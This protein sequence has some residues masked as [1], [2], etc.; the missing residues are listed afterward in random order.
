M[1][2]VCAVQHCET[3]PH[4]PA[5]WRGGC[6]TT[7]RRLLFVVTVAQAPVP[8]EILPAG[9][10]EPLYRLP[11]D[12][13][14]GELPVLPL[15]ITGA[16]RWVGASVPRAGCQRCMTVCVGA[17]LPRVGCQQCMTVWM[18]ASLPRAGC[19]RCMIVWMHAPL[20]R[21]GC[22]RCMTVCPTDD[23]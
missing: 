16:I 10:Y 19:Q 5:R 6:P 11:L 18:Q 8:L 23:D 3:V 13:Q 21:V 7:P 2:L 12:V 4:T 14:S 22:Q 9:Q 20:P 15:S 1:L 17:P